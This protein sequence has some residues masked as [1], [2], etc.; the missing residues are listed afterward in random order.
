M[1]FQSFDDGHK[2][3]E[4]VKMLDVDNTYFEVYEV[5]WALHSHPGTF[6][7]VCISIFKSFDEGT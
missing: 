6:A 1:K 4:M 5:A 2:Q 3:R 7:V